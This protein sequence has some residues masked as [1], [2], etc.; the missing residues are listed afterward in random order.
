MENVPPS[1]YCWLTVE[2]HGIGNSWKGR[3][4]CQC[5][6]G[7]DG[8]LRKHILFQFANVAKIEFLNIK[9]DIRAFKY[10]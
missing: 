6:M 9:R 10:L 3:M 5:K 8:Q 2:A 4:W 7:S 1:G